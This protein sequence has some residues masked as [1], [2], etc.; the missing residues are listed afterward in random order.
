MDVGFG[1]KAEHEEARRDED[2]GYETDFETDLGSYCA[3]CFDVPRFDMVFL[4]NTV[5]GVLDND[6]A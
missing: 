4:I 3:S 6:S 2:A 5:R 1:C